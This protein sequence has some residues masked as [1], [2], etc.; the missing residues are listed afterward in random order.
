MYLQPGPNR[1]RAGH[2]REGR[3]EQALV[4]DVCYKSMNDYCSSSKEYGFF[5][6]SS[7]N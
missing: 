1:K 3:N 5:E 4:R 7:F 2:N 6:L